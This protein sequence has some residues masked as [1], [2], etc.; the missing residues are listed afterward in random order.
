MSNTA[1]P[2]TLL[3]AETREPTT[4]SMQRLWLTGHVLP[5]GAHLFVEHVFRSAEK[6]ALEVIYSF[7][8]PRDSALRKFRI[9]GE[10]FNI[11]SEL[12]ETEAAIQS[13]EDAITMGSL[14]ALTRQYGDGMVNLTVGNIR[15]DEVV[16]ALLR[17]MSDGTLLHRP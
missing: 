10:G 8:L 7:Q 2:F 3:T 16:T 15:P 9:S 11:H 13:Y 4:L 14:A 1:A 6:K 12:R 5:V 17:R